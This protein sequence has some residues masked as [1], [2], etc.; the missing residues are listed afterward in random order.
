MIVEICANSYES[1]INAQQA[2]AHRI[3]LCSELA[4]GGVTPSYGL[5]K[6]VMEDISI[7][8]NVLIRPRSG[9]FTYSE[10]EFEIMK[11]DIELCKELGCNGIVSGLLLDDHQTIDLDRTAEL[12][13]LARPLAFTFHR[14]FDWVKDPMDSIDQLIKIGVDRVLTSGQK[15]SAFDAIELLKDL[16]RRAG[17][18]LIVMPGGGVNVHNV[19][20]FKDVGIRE[21]HFTGSSSRNSMSKPPKV[22]MNSTKLFDETLLSASDKTVIEQMLRLLDC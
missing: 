22:S 16:Q 6:K 11:Q 17:E 14:A 13:A 21:I 18:K 3:E 5:L 20:G 12:V 15:D 9:D 2:G 7:P 10:E 19:A 1:A 4:L 8:V